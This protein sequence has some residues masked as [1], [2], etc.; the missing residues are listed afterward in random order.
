MTIELAPVVDVCPQ[1]GNGM[2]KRVTQLELTETV[3]SVME[4]I[5]IQ[6]KDRV[7]EKELICN[8]CD[9]EIEAFVTLEYFHDTICDP[10]YTDTQVIFVPKAKVEQLH[11]YLNADAKIEGQPDV[12]SVFSASFEQKDYVV[13]IQVCNGSIPYIDTII[14]QIGGGRTSEEPKGYCEIT[15][16]VEDGPLTGE[17]VFDLGPEH[18][19][20]KLRVIVAA[21]DP[22]TR[23][24]VDVDA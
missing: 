11:G 18:N 2:F 10:A 21:Y 17:Y 1:C 23:Q 6:A 14:F 24:V 16:K 20:K 13:D 15:A 9:H 5:A 4:P 22:D 19:H 3:N 7:V 8:D 12:I